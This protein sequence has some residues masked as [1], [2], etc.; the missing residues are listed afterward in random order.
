YLTYKNEWLWWA[1][2][3]SM[4]AGEVAN[5]FAYAFTP[6]LLVIPL[7]ALSVLVSAI[8][9]S[10][11]LNE[12][13]N[14]HGKIGFMV[15]HAL[16]EEEIETL[17]EMSHKLG[18]PGFVVFATIVVMVALILISVIGPHHGQTNILLYITI[19][20]V[21]GVFSV[22]CAKGLGITIK[23]LLA[24]KPGLRHPLAWIL[25]LSLVICVILT[26][27]A[28]LFK[29]WQD[30]PADDIIGTLSD[31]S[32]S[33]ASLPVSFQKDNKA[34]NGNLPTMYE[35]FNN[36]EESLSCEIEQHSGEKISWRNGNLTGF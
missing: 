6:A 8:L 4:G 12:R 17:N 22:Y 28:I 14:L 18:D 33:L 13:L 15:I 26:C 23:E 20:S 11:F 24:G 30:M 16:K 1:G 35:V 36:N 2:L 9:S 19:F 27:S 5:F 3:L 32:F 10:Y 31:V 34:M 7:G 21:I 25:L 29:E